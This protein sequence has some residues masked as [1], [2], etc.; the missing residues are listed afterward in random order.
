[1]GTTGAFKDGGAA[2]L[3]DHKENIHR[4]TYRSEWAA[5][6]TACTAESMPTVH[7]VLSTTDANGVLLSS[8]NLDMATV[9][10]EQLKTEL[11]HAL[12][13]EQTV[14]YEWTNLLVTENMTEGTSTLADTTAVNWKERTFD[15]ALRCW[16]ESFS[17]PCPYC[18]TCPSL[19]PVPLGTG[20]RT[21]PVLTVDPN[22]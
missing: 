9:T 4:I 16:T 14:N 1:M 2:F 6:C 21:P 13:F 10:V 11:M 15:I 12:Q 18:T 20:S 5:T 19:L 3:G 8:S 7:S 22:K 17:A